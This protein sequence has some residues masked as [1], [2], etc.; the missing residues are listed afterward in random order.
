MKAVILLGCDGR[1]DNGFVLCRGVNNIVLNLDKRQYSENYAQLSEYIEKVAK[2]FN[3]PCCAT[4]IIVNALYKF[5]E[6]GFLNELQYK[7]ITLFVQMHKTCGLVLK[8]E[9][10]GI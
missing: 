4:N 9:K 3:G 1:Q 5:Y 10:N 2:L 7:Y 8:L 6:L